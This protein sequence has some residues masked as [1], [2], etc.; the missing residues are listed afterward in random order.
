MV[1]ISKD[2]PFQS[3]KKLGDLSSISTKVQS[4]TAQLADIAVNAKTEF[5]LTGNSIVDDTANISRML[6]SNYSNIIIPEGIYKITNLISVPSGAPK[7]ITG[8]GNVVFS[9]SLPLN[10]NLFDFFINIE[11]ENMTFDFNGGNVKNGLQYQK[12]VGE[13]NL[14]NIRIKN[15]KDMADTVSTVLVNIST[16]GNSLKLNGVHF[17]NI[18]K[19]GNGNVADGGGSL[20]GIYISGSSATENVNIRGTINNVSFKRF[21]NIDVNSNI[22]FEDTAGIYI[23]TSEN[24]DLNSVK[25]S[26]IEGYNFGKRLIKL[27]TSNIEIDTVFGYSDTN[28]ALSIIGLNNAQGLGEKK[29]IQIKNITA[30]GLMS[31]AIASD[32]DSTTIENVDIKT[33]R[34]IMTGNGSY[35]FGIQLSGSH[36]KLS[37]LR[38][39]TGYG[40]FIKKTT[41]KIKNLQIK[42]TLIIK[43]S[44]SVGAAINLDLGSDGIDGLILKDVTIDVTDSTYTGNLMEFAK[45]TGVANS[46]SNNF[47]ISNLTI[48]ANANVAISGAYFK[49]VQDIVFEN[50]TYINNSGT[51]HY[52][53]FRMDE[54]KDVKIKNINVTGLSSSVCT[55]VNTTNVDIDNFLVPSATINLGLTNTFPVKMKNIDRTKLVLNDAVSKDGISYPVEYKTG[56][57][58]QRP[59]VPIQWE[60]Y[61]D[62]TLG[63]PIWWN[64]TVW[65]DAVGTTV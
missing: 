27:H 40:I 7:K 61:F 41:G 42:D 53:A 3:K 60:M 45:T 43:N 14:K 21:H 50:F 6:N 35:A 11:F 51:S 25:I 8:M 49:Y 18:L 22:I 62:T 56:T 4:H 63:K 16:I 12:N 33:T 48:L 10:V 19:K 17:E 52:R 57:T 29:N 28:D 24:D 46:V 38:L 5:G 15:V 32:V 47:K 64:G 13:I 58:A 44:T 36:T 30:R 59:T 54:C 23:L 9:I 20:N 26:N 55:M 2:I 1:D 31:S 37:K 34:P 39:D 65:K